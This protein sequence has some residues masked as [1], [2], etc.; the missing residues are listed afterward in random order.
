MKTE[1]EIKARV[2]PNIIKKIVELA[3]GFEITDERYIN[4]G[5]DITCPQMHINTWPLF[6]LLIHRAVEGWNKLHNESVIVILDDSLMFSKLGKDEVYYYLKNYQT[7]NLT[8]LE[9]ALLDCLVDVLE[10]I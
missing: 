2:T 7:K 5:R 9:C 1:S 6:P 10:E 3:E 4:F 8:Q